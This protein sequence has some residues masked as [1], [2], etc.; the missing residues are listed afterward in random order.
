MDFDCW[1]YK[2]LPRPIRPR[3]PATPKPAKPATPPQTADELSNARRETERFDAMFRN[4]T[5]FM[6]HEVQARE[7]RRDADRE[8]FEV[9]LPRLDRKSVV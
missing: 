4:A 9:S 7:L 6:S 1:P 5:G 3:S 8:Y 2:W